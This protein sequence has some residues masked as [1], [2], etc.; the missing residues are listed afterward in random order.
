MGQQQKTS[1]L[2][3]RGLETNPVFAPH[4]EDCISFGAGDAYPELM[5]DF[6]A[7]ATVALNKYRAETLQYAPRLGLLPFREWIIELLVSEGI[8]ISPTE[9]IVVSGAKQGLDLVCKLLLNEGDCVAVT[10]PTYF[11]GIPI[12]RSHGVSF[13]Q[14]PQD[15]EGLS[16]DFLRREIY[17]RRQRGQPTPKLIYDI[18]DFHNPTGITMSQN[19]RHDLVEL[20]EEL[21]IFIVEDSPYR[22]IRFEGI[23]V[24]PLKALDRS[25]CV[26]YL[27]TL[28]KV[29]APGLRLGWI[30]TSQENAA[31]IAQLKADGGT[32][33]LIQRLAVEYC[34]EGNLPV[35]LNRVRS[36]YKRHR[37]I[38]VA[39]LRKHIPQASFAVPQ[40]GY[41][42]WV[43]FPGGRDAD[44]IA[45]N[46][47]EKGV[48]IISGT[49]F[50]A[51]RDGAY[52]AN[53]AA[54]SD[55]VRL[56]FSSASPIEI[57]DGIGR[58]AELFR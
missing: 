27:G 43:N 3:R 13:L 7:A 46:A 52:P 55:F 24:P 40:G 51:N 14:V 58:L 8:K 50:F 30:A 10:G 44:R 34:A 37:D 20:A 33:P 38:M 23:G 29:L 42:I 56:A 4:P 11:T 22:Q 16:V 36:E 15:A 12:F 5:P 25:G 54:G 28:S 48:E 9:M 41:Y 49:R 19:R 6:T 35:H 57:E 26:I 18:P 39:A 32:S 53:R 17:L 47:L 21:S 45:E 1:A 31:R 2:S